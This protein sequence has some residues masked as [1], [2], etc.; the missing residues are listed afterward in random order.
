MKPLQIGQVALRT[1]LSPDAIRF[2]EKRGLVP[3]PAR[4][5][6][7]YRLYQPR[8]IAD[9]EFIQMAQKLGFSLG[10][11]HELAAMQRQPLD[12]CGHV[13]ELIARK[14]DVVRGKIR[15]LRALETTLSRAFRQCR[16]PRERC[17]VLEGIGRKKR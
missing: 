17:P 5:A 12:A 4:S 7:G 1:G 14:L 6:G 8:E 15:E 3:R 9:L 16:E 11:I 10:E 13:R 2:Y